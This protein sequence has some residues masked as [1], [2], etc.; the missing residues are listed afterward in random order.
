MRLNLHS[1]FN[2]EEIIN[3]YQIKNK[4]EINVLVPIRYSF[5]Y[6]LINVSINNKIILSGPKG[7]GK[8]SLILKMVLFYN[9]MVINVFS[10]I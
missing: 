6:Y 1:S 5:I 7:I 8:K 2:F 10:L 9:L 3:F 4:I